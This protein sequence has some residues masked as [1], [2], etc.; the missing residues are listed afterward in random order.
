MNL[1]KLLA[2]SLALVGCTAGAA[3]DDTGSSASEDTSTAES[4]TTPSGNRAVRAA[5]Q[6]GLDKLHADGVVGTV[7]RVLDGRDTIE[8]RTGVARLGSNDPVRFDTQF[9]MGSNTKT[10]VAIVVLQLAEEGKL[11]L[12][13]TVERWLPGLVSGNGNDGK[14]ITIRQ[15]LQH[16]SGLYNYTGD[17]FDP[18]TAADYYASRFQHVE[19][20]ELV[21]IAMSHEPYFAPGT[22][23][24]YSNTNYILAG[25]IVEKASGRSWASEVRRRIIVPLQ[26]THTLEPGDWPGLPLPHAEGYSVLGVDEPLLNTTLYNHTWGGAAGSL[27]TN[28]DDLTRFWRALQRGQLL[29]RASMAAMH[30]TVEATDIQ[31]VI[32]GARYG[33]GIFWVKTACGGYWMHDGD[34]FGFA[35]RN[36]VDEDGAR[37]LVMSRNAT[38]DAGDQDKALQWIGDDIAMAEAVMCAGRAK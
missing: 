17:L 13:D 11:R 35:T 3:V 21:A 15:L 37:V 19:P 27:I 9:R 7:A 25:L 2:V 10:F 12:D 32:P 38:V 28:L 8:A 20:D 6:S 24:K 5:L 30:D 34:T 29:S 1:G 22:S 14:K 18:Y 16:T 23:W 36:G 4:R 31:V 33:L 26:L